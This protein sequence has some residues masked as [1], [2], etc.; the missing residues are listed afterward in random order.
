MRSRFIYTAGRLAAL[1]FAVAVAA[2]TGCSAIVES[3]LSEDGGGG[4]LPPGSEICDN[5]A[6]DDD[7]GRT[8]CEDPDC[9]DQPSC[10]GGGPVGEAACG[11]GRTPEECCND[12]VD[13]NSDGLTDCD[14]PDCMTWP[15]CA[16][17]VIGEASCR[18]G[19]PA[20]DCCS[21]GND[22]DGDGMTDW[23]DSECVTTFPCHVWLLQSVGLSNPPPPIESER[24]CQ[25]GMCDELWEDCLAG[26]DPDDPSD[27]PQPEW[28]LAAALCRSNTMNGEARAGLPWGCG[29]RSGAGVFSPNACPDT[30]GAWGI[31]LTAAATDLFEQADVGTSRAEYVLT[32]RTGRNIAECLCRSARACGL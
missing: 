18:G 1:A 17:G 12:G 24:Q 14:D 7:D 26:E 23:D 4:G 25:C 28:C 6:D 5:G 2:S 9:T 15:I 30:F 13:N 16:G 11:G 29:T 20:G 27:N 32:G 31:D 19:Q 10:G 3:V 22:N 8:D 21:D